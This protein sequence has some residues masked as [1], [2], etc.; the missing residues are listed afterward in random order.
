MPD[1]ILTDDE[2]QRDEPAGELAF[3]PVPGIVIFSTPF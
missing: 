2:V 1:V 3:Q